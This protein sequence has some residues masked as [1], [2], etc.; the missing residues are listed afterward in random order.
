M[1]SSRSAE[2]HPPSWLRRDAFPRLLDQLRDRFDR[3]LGPVVRD[4]AV[5]QGEIRDIEDLPRGFRDAQ[6]PGHYRLEAD[7]EDR[8][9][10]VV[11]GPASLKP[12][13]FAPR[14]KLLQIE[15]EGSG[16]R[17]QPEL[18]EA[19]RTAVLGVRACDLAGLAVQ[20]RTFLEGYVP[21][22]WFKHRRES[23]FLVAVSCTR[24]VETCFC[25]SFGT[26]PEAREGYDLALTEL[27]TGFVVRAQGAAGHEL[28]EALAL[29]P[30]SAELLEREREELAACAAGIRR[31][32]D[33][34][35]LP[36]LLYARLDHPRW[37]EVA[38]R[39][40]SCG[41]CTMVC[42]TCFCHDMRDEPRLDG[43]GSERLREWDSCF[44]PDHAQVHGINFRPHVRERYRQWLTHK[45]AGWHEQFGTSGCVGCGRCLTW[46]PVGIDLTEEVAAL[47]EPPHE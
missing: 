37:D 29:P 40:L 39:C 28:L 25:T 36:E 1:T 21:D 34:E 11:H 18:P 32:M 42:P 3:V 43:A 13:V 35:G 10:G 38:G 33:T 27:A 30:A 26:G 20:Q 15:L 6:T 8:L 46:C 14:E 9:F 12:L 17:A 24:S 19:P 44:D 31:E 22:P 45:L 47:R 23:L 7:A 16:F 2:A 5:V 41:N 4:G